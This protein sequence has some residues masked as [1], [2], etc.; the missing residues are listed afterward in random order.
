MIPY[1][2]AFTK[3]ADAQ[4]EVIAAWWAGK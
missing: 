4:A 1:R 2:V 3:T